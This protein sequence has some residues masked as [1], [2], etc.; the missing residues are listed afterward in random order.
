MSATLD[1]SCPKC[2]KVLK[3]PA[4]YEGKRVKC[5]DCKEVFPVKAPPPKDEP[6]K[7]AD[8]KKSPF[9]D[10]DD[11]DEKNPKPIEMVDESFIPRCPHCAGELDP[12]DAAV[13]IHCGFNNITR[14][15]AET[16]KVYAP[17]AMDWIMHLTPG[18][19]ALLLVIGAIG[20]DIYCGVNMRD[21]LT[22]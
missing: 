20:L 9:L 5:K 14:V 15:K 17:D 22:G 7:A 19:I 21:W 10:D 4:E 2:G 12:P 18:I 11:E 6:A 1:I 3:V 13:C 8:Q 16:K